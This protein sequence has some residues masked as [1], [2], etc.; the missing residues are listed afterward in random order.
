MISVFDTRRFVCEA[1]GKSHGDITWLAVDAVERPD[2]VLLIA[3]SSLIWT[4]C[5]ECGRRILR[6]APLL[7]TRLSEDAPVLLAIPEERLGDGPSPD[8]QALML[9]VRGSLGD[10][11]ADVSGPVL[12]LPL[13]ALQL[14]TQRQLSADL[15]TP[16]EALAAE[17]LRCGTDAASHYMAFVAEVRDSRAA[18]RLSLAMNHLLTVRSAG[19]LAQLLERYPEVH[20]QAAL[21][22][23]RSRVALAQTDEEREVALAYLHM[24]EEGSA[25]RTDEAFEI[26]ASTAM[27]AVE[28][29]L[30][31]QV[32]RFAAEI[33]RH[34]VAGEW[35]TT[36]DAAEALL[37]LVEPDGPPEV[38]FYALGRLGHA[39]YNLMGHSDADAIER[40]YRSYEEAHK[41]LEASPEVAPEQA[42]TWL[43]VNLGA[44]L[45]ARLYGDHHLNRERAIECF[46]RA[47][48][49]PRREIDGDT[50]AMASTNL[51]LCL[52]QRA[53]AS[54]RVEDRREAI[55]LLQMALTWRT[56]ARN[57]GDWAYTQINLGMAYVDQTEG[58]RRRNIQKAIGHFENAARGFRS[59]GDWVNLGQ[60]LHNLAG[61]TRSLAE[62]RGM[63]AMKRLS[64]LADAADYARQS[65]DARPASAAPIDAGRTWR[66][67]GDVLG[68]IGDR[69]ASVE[70]YR[71]ALKTL[72][73]QM[74]SRYCRDTAWALAATESDEGNWESAAE[75][76]A[77][78]I[79]AAAFALDARST[80]R[81]RLEELSETGE[82]FRWASYAFARAGDSKRAVETIELGRTQELANWLR[83]ESTGLDRVWSLDPKLAARFV[84]LVGGLA[85]VERNERGGLQ[86]DQDET[87]RTAEE[88][89][90][91]LDVIRSL[92]G[93]HG[94]LRRPRFDDL[95]ATIPSGSAIAYVVTT[96]WG[97]LILTVLNENRVEVIS[98]AS[99][100]STQIVRHLL[101]V[102]PTKMG[103]AGYIPSQAEADMAGLEVAM[104]QLDSVL[105]PTLLMP[106]E[107]KLQS[108]GVQSLSVIPVGLL[109]LVPLATLVWDDDGQHR[110]LLDTFDVLHAPSAFVTQ[111]CRQHAD[112]TE[113]SPARL[114]AVGNPLPQQVPLPGAE[115]EA[116][117]VASTFPADHCDVLIGPGATKS[118]VLDRFRRATHIHLACHGS[119]AFFDEV[120]SACIWLAGDEPMTAAELLDLE[121]FSPRLVVLSACE[122][123]IIQ[124]HETPD[125]V[126]SLGNLFL[127]AGAAGVVSTLWTVDDYA[128]ALLMSRFYERLAI[129]AL[130]SSALRAAQLW[131]RDL[132]DD[133][134]DE[135]LAERP[136]LRAHRDAHESRVGGGQQMCDDSRR[137]AARAIWAPFV[138]SGA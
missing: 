19:D 69:E 51:A 84:E 115:M 109:S 105:G 10:S 52:L 33:D 121:G 1:C 72:T 133:A 27:K 34:E 134:E 87:A 110:C 136:A 8:D 45:A 75:A 16:S 4:D 118:A 74:A 28:T 78:A 43:E 3:E 111:I 73:P 130:P 32:D 40:A 76:W 113:G 47:L 138:F 49:S 46:R 11:V 22:E 122:T 36:L 137:F 15:K 107:R 98:A 60:A 30:R 126:L 89:R 85:T 104:G 14:A 62:T 67:L 7:V 135:Y 68:A 17:L 64:L 9:R 131:L 100:T 58:N 66:Q 93:L 92:P 99:V 31:P 81:R 18:R 114:L 95:S 129:G 120:L 44:V 25:G 108:M 56:Y 13:D 23:F 26:L 119:A 132:S 42:R 6:E 116:G 12:L 91:T 55:R 112:A 57:P 123:G 102:D 125:E 70:A 124:G 48:R 29:E 39:A 96:P 41:M 71:E 35:Q 88:Y 82:V 101:D 24:V 106:L 79:E 50:W 20:S 59:S 2:L 97:S 117:M 86:T 53:E 103:V 65:L 38:R 5:P 21:E 54:N 90:A 80:S 77:T 127:A 94:F 61:A 37:R 128:T 83:D 63:G